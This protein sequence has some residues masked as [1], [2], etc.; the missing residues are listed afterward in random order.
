MFAQFGGG[1]EMGDAF[2]NAP[3]D[4][5][6]Q[7]KKPPTFRTILQMGIK[8]QPIDAFKSIINS[9][10]YKKT[11]LIAIHGET[12]NENSSN[13]DRTIVP[14]VPMQMIEIQSRTSEE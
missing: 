8:G 2:L 13:G 6:L 10:G 11:K 3:F 9:R 12:Q 7:I 5:L 1:G 4:R 14:M